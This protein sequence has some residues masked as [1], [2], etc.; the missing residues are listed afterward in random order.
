MRN[1]LTVRNL[2]SSRLLGAIVGCLAMTFSFS[3][4]SATEFVDV[5]DAPSVKMPKASKSLLLDI[6]RAGDRLI[7]VG[8]YG[9][10]VYSDDD[11]KSWTQADVPVQTQL[12]AV[13][14]VNTTHGWVVGQDAIVLGTT[15]S[16]ETWTKLHDGYM[17]NSPIHAVIKD[18]EEK[19]V[20]AEYTIDNP[21]TDD[22][23]E[24]ADI[25]DAFYEA[26]DLAA[27]VKK[28]Q[29]SPL[30]DVWF[31]NEKE[32]F[33]VGAYAQ[34]YYTKNGGKTWTSWRDRLDNF[35]DHNNAILGLKDGSLF[36]A[37]EKSN[38]D[39]AKVKVYRSTDFGETWENV[40]T[41]FDRS[42]YGLFHNPKSDHVYAMGMSGLVVRSADRGVS[43]TRQPLNLDTEF[44]SFSG[45]ATKRGSI[46]IVGNNGQF[47]TGT[48]R[49]KKLNVYLREDRI[50]MTSIVEA[51][52]GNFVTTG[53]RGINR[54]DAQGRDL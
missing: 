50:H 41:D 15:D 8:Q 3:A 53:A 47:T 2:I 35:E 17:S 28:H 38:Y 11:G 31:K 39:G 27:V 19:R 20:A 5:L 32:G 24:L 22:P 12:N 45:V 1:D 4:Q 51:A 29:T 10:I 7:A 40:A 18:A 49:S 23:D 36:V 46:K 21:N 16:G 44:L 13:Y 37:S 14:F 48:S 43:W 9:H 42:L 33:T 26:D 6:A 25:E 52:D 30:L 34:F 54:V